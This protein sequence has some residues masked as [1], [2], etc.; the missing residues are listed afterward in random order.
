MPRPNANDPNMEGDCYRDARRVFWSAVWL[1]VVLVSIKAYYLGVPDTLGLKDGTYLRSLAAISYTD[2]LFA[3]ALWTC[4][5]L[6]L[7]TVRRLP[8]VRHLAALAFMAF[9]AFACV[10][11]VVNVVVFGIFGGF[12]T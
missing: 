7:L 3:A 1:A 9:A 2:V 11:A 4:G 12:L 5:R 8:R 6:P 10:Y